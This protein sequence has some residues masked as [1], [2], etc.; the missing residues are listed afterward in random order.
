MTTSLL[1]AAAGGSL[2]STS[3]RCQQ[4]LQQPWAAPRGCTTLRAQGSHWAVGRQQLAAQQRPSLAAQ[5][6]RRAPAAA[7]AVA[8]AG[9]DSSGAAAE[10]SSGAS[11]GGGGLMQQ[12]EFVW[13][14][15]GGL[16][17]P[18]S[19][20]RTIAALVLGGEALVRILQG[21]PAANCRRH[22]V[23]PC[24]QTWGS[25]GR[26]AVPVARP[27]ALSPFFSS[28]PPSHTQ[29]R[30]TGRIRLSSWTWW[31]PAPWASACSPPRSWAWCSPS[32]S[33]GGRARWP[34]STAR[35]LMAG[36]PPLAG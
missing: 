4:N 30:S 1:A 11:S 18:K 20:W 22:A 7:S 13:T 8:A 24:L 28:F 25:T 35:Q 5:H 27:A 19:L 32:S 17:P 36:S 16:K 9:G 14:W 33:S 3:P 34:G 26:S 31:G 23:P 10:P 6:R 21:E 29:A 2:A 15:V 12:L